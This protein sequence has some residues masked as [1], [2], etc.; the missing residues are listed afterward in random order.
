[1]RSD[2]EN[3]CWVPFPRRRRPPFSF[4][5]GARILLRHAII[6]FLGIITFFISILYAEPF[7]GRAQTQ[8]QQQVSP[9]PNP[10]NILVLFTYGY[11]LPAYE[12]A[13]PAFLA[14]MKTAGVSTDCLSFEYLDLLRNQD[15]KHRRN[16]LDLLS[17]KYAQ[18]KIDLIITVHERALNFLLNEG[19]GIS[20]SA[21]VLSLF[22]PETINTDGAG[23]RMVVMPIR[24]DSRGTLERAIELFPQLKRVVF[25]VG[26]SPGDRRYE[27]EAK[28]A[29]TPWEGRLE[30]EYTSDLS[31]EETLHRVSNLP[32]QS[33]VIYCDVFT[34]RTGR[35]FVP[36]DVGEM[37]AKAANA[38][39]FGLFDT[40]LGAGIIGGSM[41]SF[42]AEGA[43]AGKLAL[44][45]LS[46]TLP[47]AEQ[48]TTLASSRTPMFDWQQIKKWGASADRLPEGSI[49]VNHEPSL[50]SRYRSLIIG[51]TVFSILQSLLIAAL[52]IQRRHRKS[53]EA[54]LKGA[55]DKYR[56]IFEGALEGIYETSP[57]GK[58]LTA[59]P[60][61][62]KM[63]GYDSAEEVVSSVTD[64]GHQVWANPS[65]RAEYVRLLEEQDV[66]RNYECQYLRKD[67]TRIWV[68]LNTRRVC[69]PDGQ[70]L[71]YSGFIEDISERKKAE[72][73]AHQR[74]V[75]L[76]HVTRVA[77]MGELTASLAHEISQP[78]TAI[79]SNAQAAR[80][81]L[82]SAVPDLDEVRQ[83]LDDI[84]KDD[85]RVNEVVRRVRSFLK[86]EAIQLQPV[87]LNEVIV[88]SIGFVENGAF[89][90]GLS[91]ATEL[92]AALPAVRADRVQLQQVLFNLMMNGVA[93]MKSAPYSSRKM[94]VKTALEDN[95]DVRVSICDSG[96]GLEGPG[97][98]RLFEPF[99]T[100]KPGGL[101]MGLSISRT[102]ITAHGGTIGAANNPEAGATF[103]FTLPIA[104]GHPS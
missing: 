89:L 24:L 55:E 86:K 75:E 53:A 61:L 84:I 67:K 7:E 92:N 13:G 99:Y 100:T 85:I 26:A 81:F 38:P 103:H 71:Y 77:A 94:V 41:L 35:T 90:D 59:N 76:A 82:S 52:L 74:M 14:V 44:D 42:E 11:G 37:V 80:R 4:P 51:L 104:G 6:F 32:P 20:P 46:G 12:K 10:K 31:L 19:K 63:L 68:A 18:R 78:L 39:V 88:E 57:A 91:I 22:A 23:R 17:H 15:E 101:G 27:H 2:A 66:V 34:D 48:V 56:N 62:A 50:W 87:D 43:R 1:M 29:F 96:S 95:R 25:V 21:P 30:F 47:V 49:F 58:N 83:I 9:S 72:A 97:I 98:E 16:L 36:R 45:I 3:A 79:L 65:E 64:S 40:L 60:A 73:E 33:I 69:G 8:L 54:S 5:V 28:S 102:I 93:A 70:T